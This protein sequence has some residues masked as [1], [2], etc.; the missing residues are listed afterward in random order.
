MPTL[1]RNY[2]KIGHRNGSHMVNLKSEKFGVFGNANPK[3]VVKKRFYEV[4]QERF[5]SKI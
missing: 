4:L 5:Q 1:P 3:N 2:N